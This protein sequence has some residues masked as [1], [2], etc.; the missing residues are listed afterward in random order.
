MGVS[1]DQKEVFE[2]ARI[3]KGSLVVVAGPLTVAAG[4]L[5]IP[6]GAVA[7]VAAGV[8]GTAAGAYYLTRSPE[9]RREIRETVKTA[10][11]GARSAISARR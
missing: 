3:W 11:G 7:G 6:M 10:I 5:S 4:F 1:F 8:A 9:E 2:M